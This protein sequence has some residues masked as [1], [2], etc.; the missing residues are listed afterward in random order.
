MKIQ[1]LDGE[2][3]WGGI[4]DFGAQMP[5][6][7]E[8]ECTIDPTS[9]GSDQRSPLFLSSMGRCLWS[10]KPFVLHFRKGMLETD[11]KVHLESAC[12]GLKEAH[13][14][15]ARK[16]FSGSG[17]PN[18]RFFE[19][20]QYNTW[21]ELMYN[22]NQ[23][24][25]L[26]Y[27][28]SMLNNG[29]KPGILMI[30][31]G[32]SE[33]YGVFDF[34]P[35][36]FEDPKAMIEELHALG[37][38]VMLWIT[39]HISP[40]SGVFRSLRNTDILLRDEAGNFA[41]RE[42]WNGF[43]CVLDLSSP[44][45]V[46]WLRGR[47]NALMVKYGIDGF[48]FD[49][50]DPSMYRVK[51]KTARKRMPLDCTADYAALAS[52]YPFNELRA[53]WN[54]GGRPLVC[55]LQDKLHTWDRRKGLGALIP[56][57]IVQGLLGYYYGCPDMIGGGDYSSF[58]GRQ[59]IDEELYIR[60]LEA[61]L[62][63]PMIQFSI[64]P[65]RILSEENCKIVKKLL[66]LRERYTP[67][68]SELAKNAAENREPIL[69][70][71]CYEFPN[72]GYETEQEMYLLGSRYL[73]VPMLEKGKTSKTV[74]LPKGRWRDSDG[75]YYTGGV[76]LELRFPLEKLYVFEKLPADSGADKKS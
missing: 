4:V 1:M 73:V 61:S 19:V 51:D 6:T 41:I 29:M 57:M 34:Y 67:Y 59:I 18:R 24:Q 70:P 50:G 56:N 26:E 21:I 46:S 20:P 66:A 60:W 15:A 69:R 43:S 49:A 38:S 30:D 65:W 13:A 63:C 10:E 36:R 42:W 14:L 16:T 44:A 23:K 5:W 53:V 31:E 40:D 25:I 39:P 37:F 52:G 71:L 33:D 7:A 17:F 54:M 76:M 9:M 11:C 72:Q 45:A 12:G 58:T 35:G 2:C 8:S 75:T 32:W 64:A 27:A 28:H 48:K 62:L 68:I 3:W 22:Q 47:L 55:R 74:T